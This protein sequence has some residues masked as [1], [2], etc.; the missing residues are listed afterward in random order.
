M[1]S[2]FVSEKETGADPGIAIICTMYTIDIAPVYANFLHKKFV[3]ISW[4]K[5]ATVVVLVQFK[6]LQNHILCYVMLLCNVMLSLC[7][8]T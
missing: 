7:Y 2:P 1:E 5:V 3:D 8:V 4:I 6:C